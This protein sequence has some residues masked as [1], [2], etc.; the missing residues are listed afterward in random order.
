MPIL[1]RRAVGSITTT[2][3]EYRSDS[4][5]KK[6]KFSQATLI[7]GVTTHAWFA[8]YGRNTTFSH[9][10]ALAIGSGTKSS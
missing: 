9:Y 6:V 3:A 8:L 5:Q 7:W 4:S 10:H 2:V 1:Q